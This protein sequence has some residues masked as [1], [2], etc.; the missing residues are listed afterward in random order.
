VSI[1][2]VRV[3][4][5]DHEGTS[6][7]DLGHVEV[8]FADSR[9]PGFEIA[10]TVK[11]VF[12][13]AEQPGAS[14]WQT[15]CVGLAYRSLSPLGSWTGP[16]LRPAWLRRFPLER[17]INEARE[18][19]RELEADARAEPGPRLPAGTPRRVNRHEW[20]AAL[21]RF[22]DHHLA[23][24]RTPMD[25]YR[26]IATRKDVEPNLVKQWVFQAR[27]LQKGKS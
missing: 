21:L 5:G 2:I 6:G 25:V 16:A 24:E 11:R 10:V 18:A 20:Y 12:T 3:D 4:Y 26:M 15:H 19:A 27:Q 17:I 23:A 1:G 8:V 14:P 22:V 9:E 13:K 7:A